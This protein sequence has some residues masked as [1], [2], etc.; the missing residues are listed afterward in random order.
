MVISVNPEP[1]KKK[2]QDLLDQ[3]LLS[4]KSESKSKQSEYSSLLGNKLEKKVFDT[5][6]VNANGTSF[7]KSIELVSGQKFPDIVAKKYYGV[8]VKTTKSDQWKSIGSSVAEGTRVEGVERIFML[9]GKMCSP[10]DFMCR[11]YE[12]CLSEVVV[13][14]SPRYQIDMNLKAGETIFDKIKVPYDDLRKQA[15]PIK[16]VLAYYK[17]LLKEGESTWW[18]GDSEPA[19]KMIIRLWNHLSSDEKE[20][21]M[22]KG[23]CLFPELLSNKQDKFNRF[24]IWLSTKESIVCPNVR[25]IYT[26]GGTGSISFKRS[27]Y[28]QLPQI[29]MKLNN[30]IDKIK[31]S[32]NEIEEDVLNEYWGNSNSS[33]RFVQWCNLIVPYLSNILDKNFPLEDYL[34]TQNGQMG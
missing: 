11:P 6:C 15:D 14:H 19:N 29:F 9:F 31:L 21:Y 24:A 17:S 4:L 23:F 22:I 3:T 8:E 16:T 27:S 32:L 7:D 34:N 2:F 30:N 33:T 26:A 13:T 25:D 18:S 10:I 28:N 5:L 1:N 20:Y 12:E